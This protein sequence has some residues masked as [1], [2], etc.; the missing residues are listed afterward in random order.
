MLNMFGQAL[1]VLVSLMPSGIVLAIVG[2]NTD[3]T[4]RATTGQGLYER[5]KG[6]FGRGRGGMSMG[7]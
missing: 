4:L 5:G 3:R 6:Y 1:D 7:M 2:V